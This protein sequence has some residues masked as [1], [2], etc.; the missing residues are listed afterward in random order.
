MEVGMCVQEKVNGIWEGLQ[1]KRGHE[2]LNKLDSQKC[3]SEDNGKHRG[4]VKAEAREIRKSLGSHV[5]ITGL[6]S[7]D[8]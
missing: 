6:E 4:L 7:G 3:G 1:T 8:N 5:Q 2:V